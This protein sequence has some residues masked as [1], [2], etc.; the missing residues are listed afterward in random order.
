[1]RPPEKREMWS[2][3][4]IKELFES[5]RIHLLSYRSPGTFIQY[6]HGYYFLLYHSA[7]VFLFLFLST[8]SIFL[9]LHSAKSVLST[10]R[11]LLHI[12][13]NALYCWLATSQF[14]YLVPKITYPTFKESIKFAITVEIVGLPG[15]FCALFNKY[16]DFYTLK[17]KGRLLNNAIE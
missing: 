10:E 14:W 1:M 7:D 2:V 17:N 3:Y 5:I 13:S 9:S 12:M 6:L 15:T 8:T 11:S 4:D 16:Y